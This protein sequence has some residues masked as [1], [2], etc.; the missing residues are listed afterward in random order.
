L[1]VNESINDI[2]VKQQHAI[3]KLAIIGVYLDFMTGTLLCFDY[4]T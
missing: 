4:S 3:K 2:S 1:Y